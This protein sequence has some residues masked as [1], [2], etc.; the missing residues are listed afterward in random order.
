MALW[1]EW[2]RCAH[3]LSGAGSR[4]RTSL[5]LM[6]VLLAWVARPDLLGVTSFVRA[7]FLEPAAYHPLLAFFHSTALPLAPL[8]AAWVKLAMSLFS[9]VNEAGY[10]VFVAD[11]I[12][13]GKEGRKMPAV[14]C[15][16]QE[17]QDNSKAEY[18]MGHSFQ[19]LS[20]LVANGAGQAFAVPLLSV[21]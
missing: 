18:I 8:L 16:H 4:R 15:L 17:S 3:A 13:V 10:V 9:H 1:T 5:W 11:G 19:V 7:S 2:M 20:L 14:K 12:K 6:V 21:A